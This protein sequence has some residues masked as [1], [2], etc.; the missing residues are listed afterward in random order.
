MFSTSFSTDQDVKNSA[1]S[2]VVVT[3][4]S[5]LA[6]DFTHNITHDNVSDVFQF[7]AKTSKAV[8]T[9]GEAIT[10]LTCEF[11]PTEEL[12][13]N[14]FGYATLRYQEIFIELSQLELQLKV[15]DRLDANEK[16]EKLRD[17]FICKYILIKHQITIPDSL[18]NQID[19]LLHDNE[20]VDLK[21]LS[22]YKYLKALVEKYLGFMHFFLFYC[23]INKIHF[24]KNFHESNTM[25]LAIAAILKLN[26]VDLIPRLVKLGIDAYNLLIICCDL[27]F[28]KATMCKLICSYATL[29]DLHLNK[30]SGLTVFQSSIDCKHDLFNAIAA[31]I[32]ALDGKRR[33]PMLCTSALSLLDLYEVNIHRRLITRLVEHGASL[34]RIDYPIAVIAE[35]KGLHNLADFLISLGANH[36][37]VAVARQLNQQHTLANLEKQKQQM[38]CEQLLDIDST[39]AP[40]KNSIKPIRMLSLLEAMNNTE[41]KAHDSNIK[42]KIQHRSTLLKAI[43]LGNI[44]RVLQ[45]IGQG[46]NINYCGLL[47]NSNS[48][49]LQF[50]VSIVN[51]YGMPPLFFAAL[52]SDKPALMVKLLINLGASIIATNHYTQQ[53]YSANLCDMLRQHSNNPDTA[54]IYAMDLTNYVKEEQLFLNESSRRKQQD[55]KQPGIAQCRLFKPVLVNQLRETIHHDTQLKMG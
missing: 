27:D 19:E 45:T 43:G 10:K 32:I 40:F 55:A 16:S 21:T 50:G 6:C 41:S 7:F 51:A 36:R 35:Y 1:Q 52:Y 15:N 18:Q 39:L 4:G 12:A 34:N 30:S 38:I 2:Q 20:S 37:P 33:L 24:G 5:R 17:L 53:H 54:V 3:V 25:N 48:E 31:R 11:I 29:D 22:R 13:T 42:R 26:L 46:A 9:T 47:D 14:L 8:S 49:Y 44:Q 28:V 23:E